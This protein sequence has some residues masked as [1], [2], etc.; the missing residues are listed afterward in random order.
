MN[1]KKFKIMLI[2]KDTNASKLAD[3]IG[4]SHQLMSKKINNERQFK[5]D[6]IQKI[7]D[8]LHLDDVEVMNIFFD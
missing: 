7:K 3:Q 8:V 4:M 2:E 6:E 5:R 1:E